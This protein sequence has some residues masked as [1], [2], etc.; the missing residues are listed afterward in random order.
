MSTTQAVT[1]GA[2]H[3]SLQGKRIDVVGYVFSGLLLASLLFTLA[4]L[5]VLVGDQLQ[6]GLPILL[7]RGPDL[8]L[9]PTMTRSASSARAAAMISSLG[10]PVAIRVVAA[11]PRA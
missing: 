3:R 6:R 9:V 4:I 7:E 10:I 11:M 1:A 8:P 2:V 5:A